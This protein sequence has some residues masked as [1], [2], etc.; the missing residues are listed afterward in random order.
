M[1]VIESNTIIIYRFYILYTAKV[2][3]TLD[4]IDVVA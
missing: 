3:S 4:D 2:F 1:T